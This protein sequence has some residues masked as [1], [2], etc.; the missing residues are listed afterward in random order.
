MSYFWLGKGKIEYERDR[1]SGVQGRLPLRYLD[2]RQERSPFATLKI[3][4]GEAG[5]GAQNLGL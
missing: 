4:N 5:K 1:E 3:F 2:N